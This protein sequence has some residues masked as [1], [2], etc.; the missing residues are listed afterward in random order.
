MAVREVFL[1]VPE[2][3]SINVNCAKDFYGTNVNKHSMQTSTHTFMCLCQRQL[4]L[5]NFYCETNFLIQL[6]PVCS[7]SLSLCISVIQLLQMYIWKDF[8][9]ILG[10]AVSKNLFHNKS[11]I[12]ATAVGTNTYMYVWK[13]TSNTCL[14]HLILIVSTDFTYDHLIATDCTYGVLI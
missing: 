13:F 7:K 9:Y 4:P 14:H 3:M 8:Y 1:S 5:L 6:Y 10:T 2:D 11:S 12:K